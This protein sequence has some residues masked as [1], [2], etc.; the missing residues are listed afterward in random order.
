ML[1]QMQSI[2]VLLFIVNCP[3]LQSRNCRRGPLVLLLLNTDKTEV[4][5][6]GTASCLELVDSEWANIGGKSVPFKMSVK[7]L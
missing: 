6:V 7:Y 3:G 2:W 5:P 1:L 4:M